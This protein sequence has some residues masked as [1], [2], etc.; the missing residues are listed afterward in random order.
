[1]KRDKALRDTIKLRD[2]P[3]NQLGASLKPMTWLPP[4]G[5]MKNFPENQLGASLKP[6]LSL[7]I[8]TRHANFPENQLGASLK[9][10]GV[11]PRGQA[12][13]TS[14]RTNSGPH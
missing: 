6:Y 4:W 2:F 12:S 1:M 3:E 13:A 11:R 10:P 14:P 8:V 9:R 7:T 5:R